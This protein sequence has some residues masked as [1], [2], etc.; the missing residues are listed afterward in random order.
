MSDPLGTPRPDRRSPSGR[1]RVLRV[2]FI[3]PPLLALVVLLVSVRTPVGPSASLVVVPSFDGPRAADFAR[4]LAQLVPD[5]S[6]GSATA[7]Q[8][9]D[10]VAGALGEISGETVRR[11][12]F[13]A[14]GPDG[15]DVAMENV[16]VVEPG[17]STEA[18]VVVANRDDVAPGPGLDDNASGTAAV[19]ELA[20]DLAGVDR[21]R[22]LVIASTDGGTVGQAGNERLL[23][24][25]RADGL[26]PVAVVSLR[27]I[28]GP[29]GTLPI[30]FAGTGGVRTPDVL[31]RGLQ[32]SLAEQ[33]PAAGAVAPQ[34]PV[35]QVLDLIVPVAPSG[36]QVPYLDAGIAAIQLGDGT[37]GV[38]LA[39]L[40]EARLGAV[41][42]AIAQLLVRLDAE[43]RPAPPT[44]A[45][46]AVSGRIIPG[47]AI[48]LLA[49]ALLIGPLVAA[50][51]VLLAGGRPSRAGWGAA[52]AVAL[53]GAVPGVAAVLVARLVDLTGGV[54]TAPGSGWPR[55]DLAGVVAVVAVALAL[56]L[57]AAWLLARR[58]SAPPP[59]IGAIAV[60]LVAALLLLAGSPA[61]VLVAV[62]ALWVWSLVPRPGERLG[63]LAWSLGPVLAMGLLIFLLR[64][65]DPATLIGAAAT[66]A[67]PPALVVGGSVLIGAGAVGA[68]AED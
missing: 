54:S 24:D 60:G 7:G 31:L 58:V 25:L 43:P 52:L 59:L 17:A 26:R 4:R 38:G 2:A 33:Q 12:T 8:A 55:A 16:W 62:P 9:V 46:V 18:V 41:G 15:A 44:G 1:S 36:A 32:E 30:R 61:S 10:D 22:A 19:V 34:S 23:R 13:T 21:S 47:R 56:T 29:T 40:D 65:A 27:S 45:Y 48:G 68:L 67:L 57:A 20:R 53:V 14:P 3:L 50:G 49:I 39:P 28:G 5:R 6:P 66:G 35:L 42:A 63:R 64:G 51:R 11:A 37:G